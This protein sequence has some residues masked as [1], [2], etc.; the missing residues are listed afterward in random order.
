M[1][2]TY[3]FIYFYHSFFLDLTHYFLKHIYILNSS[4]EKVFVV[5]KYICKN[6]LILSLFLSDNLAGYKMPSFKFFLAM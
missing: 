1:V 6:V 5:T 2:T 4:N 3:L